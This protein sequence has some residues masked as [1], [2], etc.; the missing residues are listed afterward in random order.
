MVIFPKRLRLRS[1]DDPAMD[2]TTTPAHGQRVIEAGQ[3]FL[4]RRGQRWL[5]EQVVAA[6]HDEDAHL[7]LKLQFAPP[8]TREAD[9]L[10]SARDFR[11]LARAR[12]FRLETR[13]VA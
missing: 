11:A 5:V 9:Y 12:G 13:V 8:D 10:M 4:D 6:P 2:T 1:A 7:R 3:A